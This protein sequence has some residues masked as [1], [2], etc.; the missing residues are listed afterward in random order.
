MAYNL[1][2]ATTPT[3][4]L[5]NT[6][7]RIHHGRAYTAGGN[8]M[9]AGLLCVKDT[10][11]YGNGYNLASA[12][13]GDLNT[14]EGLL[15][16]CL[17]K[18]YHPRTQ[19]PFSMTQTYTDGDAIE[20]HEL[21]EL[22]MCWVEHASLSNAIGVKLVPGASGLVVAPTGATATPEHMFIVIKPSSSA[23]KT[24]CLYVGIRPSYK[25]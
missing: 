14:A 9:K 6:P 24:L 4:V 23:T 20:V 5:Y 21:R 3:H 11:A 2:V 25:T 17:E 12:H 19:T 22:D 7:P 13:W 16:M 1:F 8:T 18:A 10:A 15:F